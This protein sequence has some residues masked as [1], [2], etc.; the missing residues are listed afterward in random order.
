LLTFTSVYFSESGLFNGLRPI[1]IKKIPSAISGCVR[2][3]EVRFGDVGFLL[4]RVRTRGQFRAWQWYNTDFAFC[5][6]T[7]PDFLLA[8]IPSETGRRTRPDLAPSSSIRRAREGPE[9]CVNLI[10]EL[11][12]VVKDVSPAGNS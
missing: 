2:R 9:I 7:T 1:Q 6:D 5:Q 4:T 11:P 8:A 3:F 12:A 10:F